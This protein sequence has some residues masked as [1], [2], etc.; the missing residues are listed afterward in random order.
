[1]LGHVGDQAGVG[2][3]VPGDRGGGAALQPVVNGAADEDTQP[4]RLLHLLCTTTEV[5][6]Q[7]PAKY[8][9]SHACAKG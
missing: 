3:L 8:I 5:E 4:P 9:A 2:G 7:Q 6:P 1:M